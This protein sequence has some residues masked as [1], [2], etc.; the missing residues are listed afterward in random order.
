MTETTERIYT[1]NGEIVSEAAYRAW[2]DERRGGS[3]FW[4]T[5]NEKRIGGVAIHTSDSFLSRLFLFWSFRGKIGYLRGK[6]IF[7][8]KG[9]FLGSGDT[10]L[11]F[12]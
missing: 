10:T 7:P 1:I 9:C 12:L 4:L 3:G 5:M 6:G 2:L 8:W 11:Y